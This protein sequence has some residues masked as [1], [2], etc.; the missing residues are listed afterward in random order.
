MPP[1]TRV[2]VLML[3][4]VTAVD[5]SVGKVIDAG[6]TFSVDWGKTFKVGGLVLRDDNPFRTAS[7]KPKPETREEQGGKRR[8]CSH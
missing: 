7:I 3:M 2:Y 5:V 1:A 6:A 4:L 8:Q